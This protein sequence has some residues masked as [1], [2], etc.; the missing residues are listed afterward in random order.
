MCG[1]FGIV[2]GEDLKLS[3]K[4]LMRIVNCMFKLSESRGKEASGLALRFN[5]S[6]YVLKEPITSSKLVKTQQYKQLFNQTLKEQGY[7]GGQLKAPIVVLGHSRLQTNGLSEINTNN[8]PVV[9]DGAVGIHNGIIVNDAKL[10]KSFPALTKKYD[11]DTEVFLSLVQMF[12]AQGKSMVEAVR[13]VF[14]HIEGSASVAVQFDDANT[15]VL[16][17]NTGSLYMSSSQDEKILVFASEKYILE[18]V[19]NQGFLKNLFVGSSITQ[20]KAGQGY[21][22]DLNLSKR[23]MFLL[24][25]DAVENGSPELVKSKLQIVELY[26]QQVELLPD[27]NQYLLSEDV[28]QSMIETWETLYSGDAVLEAV[29]SVSFA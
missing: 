27:T 19:L 26:D 22:V 3:P 5:K 28:K 21:I 23:H 20:V 17:T 8:Q 15:L 10:W 18:Q 6:I 11:V 2:I 16:A 29:Y 13:S 1:I 24:N 7:D 4:E 14:E 25:D 9:K 12:R